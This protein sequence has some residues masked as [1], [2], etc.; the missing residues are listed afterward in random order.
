MR[1]LGKHII[2]ELYG[3]SKDLISEEKAVK[4]IMDKVIEEANISV[5]GTLWKQFE[6]YGVTGV[7]LVSESHISIHTWPEYDLVN[8]DIFTCGDPKQ[9][10]TAFESFLKYFKPKSYRHYILD[11]G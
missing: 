10:D 2:A 11:R 7:A 3:V 6:P 1:V 8:L 5:V 4:E 9:A